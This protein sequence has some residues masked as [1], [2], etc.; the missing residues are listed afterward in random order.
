MLNFL[1]HS[2]KWPIWLCKL[3]VCSWLGYLHKRQRLAAPNIHDIRGVCLYFWTQLQLRSVGQENTHRH[4]QK[5]NKNTTHRHGL[6]MEEDKTPLKLSFCVC[7]HIFK[8]GQF[9]LANLFCF[10]PLI[11]W[12]TNPFPDAKELHTL[13]R[14][15]SGNQGGRTMARAPAVLRTRSVPQTICQR[16][17]ATGQDV[18]QLIAS[19]PTVETISISRLKGWGLDLDLK[20]WIWMLKDR[21]SDKSAAPVFWYF[22]LFVLQYWTTAN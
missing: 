8:W 16:Q 20:L 5:N 22:P 2:L 21:C 12:L 6:S 7:A 14:R 17:K 13:A 1:L 9:D 10:F 15:P 19:G 4:T 11:N 3:Y 18:G